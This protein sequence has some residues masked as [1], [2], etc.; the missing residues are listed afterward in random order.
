MTFNRD[1][2]IVEIPSRNPDP[3]TKKKLFYSAEDVR[4]FKAA[5][6][7]EKKTLLGEQGYKDRIIAKHTRRR[8][9]LFK[10]QKNI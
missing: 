8:E 10:A 2:D 9:V 1:M 3:H 6:R 5:G 7:L 4:E